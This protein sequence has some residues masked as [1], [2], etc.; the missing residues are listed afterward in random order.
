MDTEA[1]RYLEKQISPQREICIQ[2]RELILRNFPDLL[3]TGM[4]EGLWYKGV[5]Y[6]TAFRD[7]VNLGVGIG[8]MTADEIKH[9]E[10][11]GKSMRHLKFYTVD[12]VHNEKLLEIMHL[13]YRN[14]RS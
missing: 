11:K 5:F 6:I 12:D 7:H 3:E 10:G 13:V 1:S 14:A 9:F 8:G 4:E 2:L